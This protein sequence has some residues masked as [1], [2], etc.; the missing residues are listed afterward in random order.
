MYG[1]VSLEMWWQLKLSIGR[2]GWYIRYGWVI[3]CVV[4][5]VMSVRESHQRVNVTWIFLSSLSRNFEAGGH[6]AHQSLH[7]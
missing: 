2:N 6:E 4:V 1:I 5:I 3:V 7:Y